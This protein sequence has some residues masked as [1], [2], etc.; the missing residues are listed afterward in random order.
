MNTAVIISSFLSGLLGA[1]GFGGGAVLIIYLTSFL[2]FEQKEA[3]GINLV[4]FLLTGVFALTSN[5]KNGLVE[6]KHI[7]PFLLSAV[8]GLVLGYFLLPLIETIILKKLFGGALI[9]LGLKEL[10]S[11]KNQQHRRD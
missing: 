11:K 3:Q 6:K 5:L 10:F 2:S 7:L 1:M 9:L 8:P 4:F